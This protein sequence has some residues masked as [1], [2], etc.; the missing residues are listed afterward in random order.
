LRAGTIE[1]HLNDEADH[2]IAGMPL[3]LGVMKQ[4]VAE[5]DSHSERQGTT[6]SRGVALF[7]GLPTGTAYTFRATATK[8]AG[9]FASEPLRLGESGGQRVLLHVFPV[10]RDLRQALVGMR[11]VVFVQ[12]RED[13]FH[14]ES[15]FQVINIGMQAWVPD[16]TKIALPEGA[17]AS[18]RATR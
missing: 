12:P 3:R 4:D 1:V 9:T 18:A 17:K 14:I 5:G 15:S 11:G 16:G 7:E 10:T 6:D 2:P 13:V 8:D